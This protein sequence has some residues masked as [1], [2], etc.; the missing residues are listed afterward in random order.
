MKS[1]GSAGQSRQLA[2]FQP[3]MQIHPRGTLE[4]PPY[5]PRSSVETSL[6]YYSQ[7]IILVEDRIPCFAYCFRACVP[8]SRTATDPLAP[9]YGWKSKR[10]WLRS[11]NVIHAWDKVPRALN[12]IPPTAELYLETRR[13]W[14]QV[15]D[16]IRNSI[17]TLARA[18]SLPFW[19]HYH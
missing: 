12:L 2:K 14:F 4:R 10:E 7:G 17:A 18:V 3:A 16:A 15:R 13:A 8:L 19:C 1:L 6:Q 5:K 9:A 11:G